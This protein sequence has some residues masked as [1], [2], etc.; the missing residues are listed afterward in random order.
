MKMSIEERGGQKREGVLWS[1]YVDEGE[2]AGFT[3]SVALVRGCMLWR[4]HLAGLIRG[5]QDRLYILYMTVNDGILLDVVSE[6][7]TLKMGK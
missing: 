3:S 1:G 7:Y 5:R 2:E 6:F 4:R